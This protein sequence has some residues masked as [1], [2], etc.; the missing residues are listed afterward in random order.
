[1]KKNLFKMFSTLPGLT[2]RNPINI[3]IIIFVYKIKFWQDR[4]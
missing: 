2:V 4:P 1:M 3:T